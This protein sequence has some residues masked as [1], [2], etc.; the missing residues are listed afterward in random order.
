VLP[1]FDLWGYLVVERKAKMK[2]G[3]NLFQVVLRMIDTNDKGIELAPLDNITNLRAVRAGTNVTIGVSGDRV[4]SIYRGDYL[5][6]LL[7]INRERF[8]AVLA[9]MEAEANKP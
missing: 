4:G 1:L 3:F 6:G 7:L 2:K 5:G 8:N 9:E